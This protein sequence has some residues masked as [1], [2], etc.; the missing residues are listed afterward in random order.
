M[1]PETPPP[2]SPLK[3][4]RMSKLI[5]LPL[6]AVLLIGGGV[7]TAYLLNKKE[8]TKPLIT[9]ARSTVT[10]RLKTSIIVKGLTN[11]WDLGFG[12]DGT[13]FFTERTGYISVL[14]GTKQQVLKQVEDV[15][16]KGEG[17]LLGLVV[18]SDFASNRYIYTCFNTKNDIRL[19]RWKVSPDLTALSERTDIIT[20]MPVSSSGRHSGCRPRFGPDG[21]LWVGTGDVAMGNNAQ[22]PASLG[23]K[24]LRVDRDGQP[25]P[26]NLKPPFDERIFS[27]GHRNTQGLAFLPAPVKGVFGYS[28]E[29]GPDR[30]DE[31]NPLEA[32]NFGWDPVPGTYNEAVPMTDLAK[33]PDSLSAVW[34]SGD[35]TIAP[36]G[37]TALKGENWLA[38]DGALAVA[39]LKGKH[40]R[41]LIF[42]QADPLNLLEEIEVLKDFGRIRSVVQGPDGNLY[43]STDNGHGSDQI[44]RVTPY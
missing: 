9:K 13:I 1:D 5:V 22:N 36:S 42:D 25:A 30:D 2:K 6:A 10:P 40:V 21:Y 28:V 33:Y 17:G 29:H 38:W 35:S 37:A 39:V 44:V 20:G 23:G 26:D 24:I 16:V 34:R 7:L 41:I 18:D 43:F 15:F 31:V 12:T 27:Y 32:G 19:V 3:I 14:V 8:N 4:P 11:P